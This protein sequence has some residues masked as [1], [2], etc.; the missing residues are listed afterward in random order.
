MLKFITSLA[1]PP[2][3][4]FIEDNMTNRPSSVQ[5]GGQEEKDLDNKYFSCVFSFKYLVHC[6][7]S[8]EYM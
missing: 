4:Q 3:Y 7:S 2:A 1:H 6:Y 5:K 8:G